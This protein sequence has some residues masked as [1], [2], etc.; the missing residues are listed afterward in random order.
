MMTTSNIQLHVTRV[1]ANLSA[2]QSI[3]PN[4][5]R[6]NDSAVTNYGLHFQQNI[7]ARAKQCVR[8]ISRKSRD[9]DALGCRDVMVVVKVSW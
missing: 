1:I 7:R 4:M 3:T 2:I 5:S 8:Y 6:D 9:L